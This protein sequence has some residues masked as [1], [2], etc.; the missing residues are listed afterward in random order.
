MTS[1]NKDVFVL[2]S[3]C[4]ALA[5]LVLMANPSMPA[6][7]QTMDFLATARKV[8]AWDEARF[9]EA[10]PDETRLPNDPS[11]CAE[12]LVKQGVLTKFQADRKSVV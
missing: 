3:R 1:R 8:A 6:S 5:F 7:T 12:T 2:C 10:V 9:A 11:A 4:A